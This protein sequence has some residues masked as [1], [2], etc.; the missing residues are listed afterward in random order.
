MGVAAFWPAMFLVLILFRDQPQDAK[1]EAMKNP[2]PL[3]ECQMCA[4]IREMIKQNHISQGDKGRTA[5]TDQH[6]TT[7]PSQRSETV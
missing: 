5:Q 6:G 4:E 1:K 7:N 2:W 3:N